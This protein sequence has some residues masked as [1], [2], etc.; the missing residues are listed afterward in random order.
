MSEDIRSQFGKPREGGGINIVSIEKD[1][2]KVVRLLPPMK[3]NDFV[4]GV[5]HKQHYGYSVRDP[6]DPTKTRMRPFLCVEEKG[7][8]GLVKVACPECIKRSDVEQK[9]KDEFAQRTSKLIDAGVPSKEAEA[10]ALEATK[11]FAEWLDA[12]NLDKKWFIPVMLED[13]NFGILKVPHAAKKAI[14]KARKKLKEEEGDRDIFDPDN[15]AWLKMTRTGTGRET[16]YDAAV[17]KEAAVLEGRRV[18]IVKPAQLSDD[19]LRSAVA[20]PLLNSASLV[21]SLT[22]EQIRMLAEGDGDPDS[23]EAVLNLGQRVVETR[24]PAPSPAR[25]APSAPAPVVVKPPPPPAAVAPTP[26]PTP[27]QDEE[28]QLLAQLAAARARKAAASAAPA[29][30]TAP[31]ASTAPPLDPDISDDEFAARFPP[32]K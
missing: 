10:Q 27:E 6:R 5:Y 23:V 26:A 16:D 21:R 2:S 13:G 29:P 1:S 24:P 14:E 18:T 3:G 25:Y 15:G 11:G 7:Q 31:A 8:D 28:A 12:H 17:V 9:R 19:Q 30:K 20:L 4:W 22:K 32:P